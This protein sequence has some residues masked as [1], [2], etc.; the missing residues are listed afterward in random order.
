MKS[1]KLLLLALVAGFALVSVSLGGEA[2]KAKNC[3]DCQGCDQC[4]AAGGKCAEKTATTEKASKPE[5]AKPAA[6]RP[7][8]VV[9]Q[10]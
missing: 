8:A 4:C 9:A 10:K 3:G 1:L 7:V 6:K 5:E 2:T